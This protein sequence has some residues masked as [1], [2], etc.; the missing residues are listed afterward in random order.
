MLIH[1]LFHQLILVGNALVTCC[2]KLG[3]S[4][5]NLLLQIR[6]FLSV[7]VNLIRVKLARHSTH[8][9]LHLLLERLIEVKSLVVADSPSVGIVLTPLL[10]QSLLLEVLWHLVRVI[11][12][13]DGILRILIWTMLSCPIVCSLSSLLLLRCLDV[14]TK[15]WV[16][17]QH[18]DS[19][20]IL[21]LS[22]LLHLLVAYHLHRYSSLLKHG[23][24]SIKSHL[25]RLRHFRWL[26]LLYIAIKRGK[27]HKFMNPDSS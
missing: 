25:L 19:K 11:H 18:R 4:F 16:V 10:S 13:D 6:N 3:M 9:V 22:H 26:H 23:R 2:I 15:V 27:W 14:E 1:I 24:Y 20:I 7:S 5:L 12:V 21:R 8:H 17:H